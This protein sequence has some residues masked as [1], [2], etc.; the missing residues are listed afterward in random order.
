[1]VETNLSI[2]VTKFWLFNLCGRRKDKHYFSSGQKLHLIIKS[3]YS[4]STDSFS[5]SSCL[6]CALKY[7][8]MKMFKK[9]LKISFVTCMYQ[10]HMF[11]TIETVFRIILLTDKK[12]SFLNYS[13]G[14]TRTQISMHIAWIWIKRVLIFCLESFIRAAANDESWNE[15]KG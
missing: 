14:I 6:S 13:S 8:H 3:M 10:Q 15:N 7:E 1:M 12:T 4:V 5:C 9:W 11:S 2:I